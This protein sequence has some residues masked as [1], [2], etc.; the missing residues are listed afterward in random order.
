[1]KIIRIH[2]ILMLIATTLGC[3]EDVEKNNGIIR[4]YKGSSLGK[5]L[6]KERYIVGLNTNDTRWWDQEGFGISQGSNRLIVSN[7]SGIFY[8][9]II[10]DTYYKY[11]I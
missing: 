5:H 8:G 9:N 7:V 4:Q 1:M 10:N 6:S 2:L 11:I 3:M